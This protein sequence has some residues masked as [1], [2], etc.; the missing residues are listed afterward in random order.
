[1]KTISCWAK[2]HAH[3]AIL[4]LI[5][6]ETLNA[7]NGL[8][9]GMNLLQNWSLA[10]LLLL[11]ILF[12]GGAVLVRL[13]YRTDQSY[14]TARRWIFGAF[15]GNFLLFGVLGGLWAESVQSPTSNRAAWG[16]QRVVMRSDTL[17][18]PANATSSNQAD[19]YA[20]RRERMAN[21]AG[22]RVLF[23]LLFV[24]GI[25]L[26]GLAAGLACNL[27]CT[28]YAG[29]AML[30]ALAGLGIFAGSFFSLSRAFDKT[31][32]PWRETPPPQRRRTWFRALLLMLGFIAL[33][34][35]SGMLASR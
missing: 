13:Q 9:L 23:V 10:G 24:A 7:L 8:L 25:L 34:V 33:W 21:P 4:L 22:T 20:S 30:V 31:L 12:G 11:A 1:M 17:I 2:R 5:G 29:A 35:I 18:N 32:R 19:Y 14:A 15:L 6:C 27:A 28:N 26:T 16:S 3:L